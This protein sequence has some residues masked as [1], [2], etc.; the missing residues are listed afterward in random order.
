MSQL[1][2]NQIYTTRFTLPQVRFLS[3]VPCVE[4]HNGTVDVY[5]SNQDIGDLDQADIEGT[6]VLAKEGENVTGIL[7]ISTR[8]KHIAF[9]PKSGS[10]EIYESGLI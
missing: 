8:V 9:V 3:A 7:P 6:M 2:T 10:P 4:I 5:A 1:N